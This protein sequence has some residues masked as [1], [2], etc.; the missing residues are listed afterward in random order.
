MKYRFFK[1]ATLAFVTALVAACGGGG[2]STAPSSG[3]AAASVV[4]LPAQLAQVPAY[5]PPAASLSLQRAVGVVAANR[6]A[7][8]LVRLSRL[9]PALAAPGKL[10]AGRPLQIGAGREVAA[11]A[12]L[13][14]MRTALQFK[15]GVGGAGP[16]AAVSFTSAGAAALRLGLRVIDLPAAARVRGY[17]QGGATAFDL[18][19]S[20]I[21]AVIARNRDAGDV[22]DSGRTFWTPAIDSEEVTLEIALPPGTSPDSVRVFVPM[23]SHVSVKST[24][25]ANLLI[26]QSGSCEIDVNCASDVAPQSAATARMVFVD[27]GYSFACTGTL[28]NDSQFSGT[29]YFLSANHCISTQTAASTLNTYWFYRSASCN[30]LALDPSATQLNGGATLL[31]A[32]TA[33]DTS[34]MRLNQPPPANAVFAGWSSSPP[35]FGQ[36]LIGVHHPR[37]D[38]QKVARGSLAAFLSCSVGV[39][40]TFNCAEASA[41]NSNYLDAQWSQGTVESGSSGSGLFTTI[42]GSR[43][44]VGQLKGGSASCQDPTGLNAYGRFDIAYTAGLNRWLSP[45]QSVSGQQQS[46]ILAASTPRIPIHRFFNTVTGAHFFT[47]SAGERDYVIAT[48][49]QFRYEGVGFYAYQ[50][51]VVGSQP[52]FRLYNRV[53]GIHF[54]TMSVAEHDIVVKDPSWNDEGIAWYAQSGSGGTASAVFRFNNATTAA[55]FYTISQGERDF[56][57]KTYPVFTY[58][59]VAYYAWT[60][61]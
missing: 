53:T 23:L 49:P 60:T 61:Q 13:Q 30:V 29:P 56:V 22:S 45:G 14:R 27:S 46:G 19:G 12:D 44:L 26:G 39:N 54:F 35:Q 11:T 36:E 10:L 43:Y 58:E 32:S 8:T 9:D 47:P 37:G 15:P 2:D 41:S 33:T 24:E 25:L 34:F 50:Q 4:E 6:P 28:L 55:H 18:A 5:Q 17:A 31:Y 40:D 42:N 16:T 20:D 1:A 51:Q 7:P 48:Y 59:G 57:I 52:V 38:L 21:L 3:T